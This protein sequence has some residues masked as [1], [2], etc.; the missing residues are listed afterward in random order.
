MSGSFQPPQ[1][2]PPAVS[3]LVDVLL[4]DEEIEDVGAVNGTQV[5]EWLQR[6]NI[7]KNWQLVELL[8]EPRMPLA[9]MAVYRPPDNDGWQAA[10]TIS[11][12][13]Y[14]GWP[15]FYEVLH[16][17]D[18]TLR[19]LDGIGINTKVLPVPPIQWTAAL[20]SVGTARIGGRRMWI[21]QSNYVAG[22]EQPHAGRL[23]VHSLFVEATSRA[24]LT[25]DVVQMSTAV[26]R[27]FITA[28]SNEH[29]SD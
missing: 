12:F 3:S 27:G 15:S 20:R 18:R 11:V 17:T 5:P 21:Q 28:L 23:V 19:A 2:L 24:Q 6:L 29:C 22:S 16:N 10:E 26:Y 9:R 1:G 14:T 8:D 4:E 25:E 13:G 7:P